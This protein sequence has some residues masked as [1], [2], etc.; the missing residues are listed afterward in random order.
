VVCRFTGQ[1]R[2]HGAP[3]TSCQDHQGAVGLGAPG[4]GQAAHLGRKGPGA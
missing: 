3:A 4:P 1:G 2:Q